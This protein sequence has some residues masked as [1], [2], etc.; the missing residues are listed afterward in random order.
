[1]KLFAIVLIAATALAEVNA[2]CS[3]YENFK[4]KLN[5]I[6]HGFLIKMQFLIL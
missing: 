2:T 4:V 1:M 6:I 3:T 5:K